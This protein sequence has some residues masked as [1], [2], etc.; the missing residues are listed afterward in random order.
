MTGAH[1]GFNPLMSRFMRDQARAGAV[2]LIGR[3]LQ[4]LA[5]IFSS[6]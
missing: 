1:L 6:E 5:A 4:L 3:T 2:V